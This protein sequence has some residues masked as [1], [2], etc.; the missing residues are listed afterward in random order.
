MSNKTAWSVILL[1]LFSISAC[2]RPQKVLQPQ[3]KVSAD[4]T[5]RLAQTLEQKQRWQDSQQTYHSAINQYQAFGE[6]RGQAYAFAGLARIA[7]FA[8]EMDDFEMYQLQLQDIVDNADP[9]SGSIANLLRIHV[10]E[11]QED[12]AQILAIAEDAYEY[13]LHI[14]M[15]MLSHRLQAE[16]YLNPGYT[17]SS[18]TDLQRLASRYRSLLKKDFSADP[19]VL[20]N[21]EYAMGYHCFLLRR[22]KEAMLH[23]QRAID[24]DYRYENFN[25]LGSAYWLRGRIHESTGEATSAK[26]DYMKGRD[27]FTHILNPPMLEQVNAALSRLQG[28]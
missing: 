21:A 26:H 16:S 24:L 15:Q 28:E 27:I 25:A 8:N 18:Y 4:A 22:Y 13:P 10:L 20:A 2:S 17:S 11:S 23:I 1:L 3:A 19:T 12:Y 7:F 5:L 9:N 14:R 6:M